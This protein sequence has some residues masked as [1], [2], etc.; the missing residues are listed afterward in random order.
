MAGSSEIIVDASVVLAVI[1]NEPEKA[2]IIEITQ[3]RD[4]VSPGCLDWEIGNAFSA[5][6]KRDRIKLNDAHRALD[7]YSLIPIKKADV[8]LALA[9]SISAS[10][11]IYAYDAYYMEVAKKRSR[12][13]MTLDSRMAEV[14]RLEGIKLEEI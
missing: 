1:L 4:L 2:R 9:L 7:V 6:L 5:M 12:P 14:S 10:H 13:I 8:D 11:R 3:G